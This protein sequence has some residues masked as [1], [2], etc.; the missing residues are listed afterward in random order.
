MNRP[1]SLLLPLFLSRAWHQLQA[2]RERQSKFN[3][4]SDAP[5]KHFESKVPVGWTYKV[6]PGLSHLESQEESADHS[7]QHVLILEELL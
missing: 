2:R 5:L 4:C 6:Y 7:F 1:G 3:T